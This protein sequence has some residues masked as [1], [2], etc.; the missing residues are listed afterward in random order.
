VALAFKKKEEPFGVI[1][2]LNTDCTP[3]NEIDSAE[4]VSER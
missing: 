3:P 2:D 1:V 4:K